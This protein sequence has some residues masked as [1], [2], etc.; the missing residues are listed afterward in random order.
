MTLAVCVI[1]V[2]QLGRTVW[3][4]LGPAGRPEPRE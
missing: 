4:A 1:G 2:A 3:A